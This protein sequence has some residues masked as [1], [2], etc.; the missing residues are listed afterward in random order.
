MRRIYNEEEL[1]LQ[2][3]ARRLRAELGINTA[4]IEIILRMRQQMMELQAHLAEMDA[5]LNRN[6]MRRSAHLARR[7][8]AEAEAI[9]NELMSQ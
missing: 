2:R 8:E 3:C 6:A 7:R 9:W 5:Q 1:A 4:G